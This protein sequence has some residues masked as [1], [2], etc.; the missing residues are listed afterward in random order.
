[1]G[2]PQDLLRRFSCTLAARAGE[3]SS[4]SMQKCHAIHD[5]RAVWCRR[6]KSWKQAM[7]A[8]RFTLFNSGEVTSP[9]AT[10]TNGYYLHAFTM[11][12]LLSTMSGS[13]WPSGGSRPVARRSGSR[14]SL[15][16]SLPHHPGANVLTIST[17][18]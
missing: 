7:H 6:F 4:K 18:T 5:H 11:R 12:I 3:S 14:L 8:A 2:L 15:V 13:A 17:H 16:N 9:P 10:S 1:M